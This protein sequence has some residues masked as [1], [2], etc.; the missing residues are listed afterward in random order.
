MNP[1]AMN[2]SAVNSPAANPSAVNS[3]AANPS[4]VNPSAAGAAKL[5]PRGRVHKTR[6]ADGA[7]LVSLF[8]QPRRTPLG[9]SAKRNLSA[10]DL[11]EIYADDSGASG[12]ESTPTNT[13]D[14]ASFCAPSPASWQPPSPLLPSMPPPSLVGHAPPL[15]MPRQSQ[16]CARKA[17]RNGSENAH[18]SGRSAHAP[19]GYQPSAKICAPSSATSLSANPL[20]TS[21]SANQSAD[22]LSA[23]PSA[24]SLSAN[25]L[26]NAL[27]ANQSAD[28]LSV[29]LL[30]PACLPT[31]CPP[32]PNRPEADSVSREPPCQLSP[33]QHSTPAAPRPQPPLPRPARTAGK[34]RVTFDQDY[35]D[36][37]SRDSSPYEG[38]RRRRKTGRG[39][40][41]ARDRQSAAEEME[42]EERKREQ[43]AKICD[44]I[45]HMRALGRGGCCLCNI[46]YA[47]RPQ[48]DVAPLRTR[49]PRACHSL[50][51]HNGAAHTPASAAH[52]TTSGAPTS[53][54]AT[55]TTA[56]GTPTTASATHTTASGAQAD[57]YAS[58]CTNPDS[59]ANPEPAPSA[60]GIY[61]HYVE[62]AMLV[63]RCAAKHTW[64][65]TYDDVVHFGRW[66][67]L[68]PPCPPCPPRL[69]S[70]P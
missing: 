20:A 41:R 37:E 39:P 54:S 16:Q 50:Y 23:N 28:V 53:T 57:R 8:G 22:V 25:P 66:C 70:P 14:G 69:P 36:T 38:K 29:D 17:A 2:P 1:P 27:S 18:T 9:L 55:P 64:E 12:D 5:T 10:A 49:A 32:P 46:H 59:K 67:P 30:P 56:S 15:Y 24:T 62:D 63:F 48:P 43:H 61:Y 6:L 7:A 47:R 40:G 42:A 33:T 34:K 21:L 11:L 68:C 13:G 26:A 51:A 60:T 19:T 3:P 58:G 31:S 65:A 4:A 45:I 44:I 35:E 52:T